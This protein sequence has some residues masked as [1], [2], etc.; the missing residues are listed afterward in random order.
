MTMKELYAEADLFLAAGKR[1][2]IAMAKAGL[3]GAIAWIKDTE[4]FGCIFTRGEYVDAL[5]Q[6]IERLGPTYH[7][8]CMDNGDE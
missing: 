5:L 7:F 3:G 1:Y 8:G 6:N 4:G 2:R